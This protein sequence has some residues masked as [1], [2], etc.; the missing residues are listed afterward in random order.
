MT[1]AHEAP[2]L[3]GLWEARAD[4]CLNPGAPPPTHRT[5][6]SPAGRAHVTDRRTGV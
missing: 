2:P 4:Y 3:E 6:P 1:W 5:I